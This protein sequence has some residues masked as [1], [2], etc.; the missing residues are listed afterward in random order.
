MGVHAKSIRPSLGITHRKS[1]VLRMSDP[2]DTDLSGRNS[3]VDT[4]IFPDRIGSSSGPAAASAE[5]GSP[6]RHDGMFYVIAPRTKKSGKGD[7]SQRYLARLGVGYR[8]ED[9]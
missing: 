1:A 2:S 9:S 7:L 3:T 4:A 6:S 5:P 8:S